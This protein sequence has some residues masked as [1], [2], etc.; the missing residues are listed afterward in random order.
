MPPGLQEGD[1]REV[2]CQ[3]QVGRSTGTE[4]VDGLGVTTEELAE[5]DGV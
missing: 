1:R 4:C 2:F 3:G 5:G